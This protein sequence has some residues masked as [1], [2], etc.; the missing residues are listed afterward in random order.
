MEMTDKVEANE[1]IEERR[2]TLEE[3]K[4]A[5][6]AAYSGDF[7]RTHQT[8][9]V[10]ENFDK[11][12]EEEEEVKIAGRIRTV[13]DHGKSCFADLIDMSG[14][15]QIY[16]RED[17]VGEREY[18]LFDK[19]DIGDHIGVEGVLF[20]TGRGE[21]TI[22]VRRFKLLSKSLRPLPEKWHGLQDV[23]LR[24]RQRYLDLIVNSE[25]R[26]TF[27]LRSEIIKEIRNYLEQEKGFL[28][29][30][31]PLM[32][33]IPGGADAN[34]FVTYH[35]SLDMELY[36]RIAPELY[37]KRLLVGGVEKVFELGKNLRNE[38]L[39]T[40]HN[41]EFTSLEVYE[42]YA[43]YKDMMVLTEN[44]IKRVAKKVMN[45]LKVKYKEEEIDLAG[46]WSKMTMVE[47]IEQEIGIDFSDIEVSEAR[48][49]ANEKGIEDSEAMS[50][51]EIINEF[52]EKFVEDKLIQPT[53]I[54]QYPVEVSPL[55]K[56]NEDNDGFT[57]RFELFIAGNEVANAF[58]ELNDPVE[59]RERFKLQQNQK[60]VAGEEYIMDE[61]FI[62]ALEYGMPPAGG[63]GIGIDRLVMILTNSPSIKEVILFPHLRPKNE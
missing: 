27:M 60:E 20:E 51:G 39:S 53:F 45:D 28:E 59:Q 5:G 21:K 11:L 56:R 19:L 17:N 42:A 22:S 8:Q 61:D 34:P 6:I 54:T 25:V 15:I 50:L 16:V 33:P 43:D 3:L 24:Y 31:T 40:K 57:D 9:E 18:E 44:L 2:K 62:K 47:A 36:M 48:H 1:L 38:G 37:L 30:Q 12:E 29:V 7:N 10:V 55:A 52:F 23:E 32:H 63:L 58:S 26:E 14:K 41:P 13:R 4:E 46:S 35:E 49:L